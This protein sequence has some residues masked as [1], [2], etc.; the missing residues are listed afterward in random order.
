M[1]KAKLMIKI[2]HNTYTLCS[3]HVGFDMIQ[4]IK[5]PKGI[6]AVNGNTILHTILIIEM[7][8]IFTSTRDFTDFIL[9]IFLYNI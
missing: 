5:K 7:I 4:Y 6:H 1:K 9:S 2:E 8:M 3:L